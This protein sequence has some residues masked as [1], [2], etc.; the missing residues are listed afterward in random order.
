M[1]SVLTE[2]IA[3]IFIFEDNLHFTFTFNLEEYDKDGEKHYKIKDSKLIAKPELIHFQ[4]DNL[5]GGDEALGKHINDVFNENW[6][7]LWEDLES[8][9]EEAFGQ[10]FSNIFGRFLEKVPISEIF[11]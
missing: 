5:F 4:L 3:L 7:A 11:A 10:I 9:Y 2:R 8:S 6:S 1:V